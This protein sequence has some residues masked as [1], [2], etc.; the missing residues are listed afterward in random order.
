MRGPSAAATASANGR[1]PRLGEQAGALDPEGVEER[2]VVGGPVG[3]GPPRGPGGAAGAGAVGRDEAQAE[4]G[5]GRR[6]G[7]GQAARAG[8]VEHHD[9]GAGGGPEQR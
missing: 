3:Q 5:G 1:A 6:R 4:L 2:R 8:A 9:G 7:A